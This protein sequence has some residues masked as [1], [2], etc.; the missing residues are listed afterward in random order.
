MGVPSD[1]RLVLT[2]GRGQRQARGLEKQKGP[3]DH[4]SFVLKPAVGGGSQAPRGSAET[5]KLE[6]EAQ[7]Q[8]RTTLIPTHQ[9]RP[10]ERNDRPN[11]PTRRTASFTAG[12]L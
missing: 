2:S 9:V 12:P 7:V 11:E 8:V 1:R 10:H 5:T 6:T 4:L 3:P